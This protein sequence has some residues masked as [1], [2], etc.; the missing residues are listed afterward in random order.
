[1]GKAKDKIDIPYNTWEYVDQKKQ[2]IDN[3][4]HL[5]LE[6]LNR[7][8]EL[9]NQ[10]NR[11]QVPYDRAIISNPAELFCICVEQG[12]Y[13]PPEIMAAMYGCLQ[14]VVMGRG[15]VSTQDIFKVSHS[16][17]GHKHVPGVLNDWLYELFYIEEYSDSE[18]KP[19]SQ[20][21]RVEE[22][23]QKMNFFDV[24]VDNFKRGYNRWI[25]RKSRD[26]QHTT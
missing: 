17:K 16:S 23:L 21:H 22:F 11:E 24:D 14:M 13:P 20:E 19:R 1:M 25:A 5:I 26:R 15:L 10:D 2:V 3:H 8:W 12:R 4:Q 6:R 7:S 18:E 9:I